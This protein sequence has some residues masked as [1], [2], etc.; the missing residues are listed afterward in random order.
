M[1]LVESIPKRGVIIQA[2]FGSSTFIIEQPLTDVPPISPFIEQSGDVPEDTGRA[3]TNL[4]VVIDGLNEALN[5][6]T[7]LLESS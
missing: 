6:F 3:V 1:R 7:S 5:I 4:G 2:D